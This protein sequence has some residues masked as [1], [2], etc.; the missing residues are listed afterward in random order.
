MTTRNGLAGDEVISALQNLSVE[1]K[2]RRL[3]ICLRDVYYFTTV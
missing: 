2:K 3:R 1:E